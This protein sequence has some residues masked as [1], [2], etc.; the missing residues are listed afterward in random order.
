MAKNK[1]KIYIVLIIV[2]IMMVG[3]LTSASDGASTAETDKYMLAISDIIEINEL[4]APDDGTLYIYTL[5]VGSTISITAKSEGVRNTISCYDS[6][7][8]KIKTFS[9]TSDGKASNID[10]PIPIDTTVYYT[11]S[12]DD[13]KNYFMS[14]D[15]IHEQETELFYFIVKDEDDSVDLVVNA[16]PTDASL[17]IDGEEMAFQAYEINKYNYFKLRDLAMVLSGTDKQFEVIWDEDKQAIVITT[18]TPYTVQGGELE[19]KD[20]GIQTGMANESTIYLDGQEVNMVA[21]NI[22]G[23]NYFK[24]RDLGEALDFAVIWDAETNSIRI[25]TKQSYFE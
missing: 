25:D 1:K 18:N 20:T 4:E 14:V 8:N 22:N 19:I 7:N 15:I 6:K 2:L 10:Q 12:S 17:L 13:V 3:V 16:E 9:M 11:V 24:L 21:Y 5:P 23:N